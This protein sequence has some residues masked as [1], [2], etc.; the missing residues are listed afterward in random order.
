MADQN[1]EGLKEIMVFDLYL[2]E[3]LK[4]R[5]LFAAD[6][7]NLKERLR[8]FYSDERNIRRYLNGYEEY[9]SKQTRRMTHVECFS[10]DVEQTCVRGTPCFLE[11]YILFDYRN[12]NA[13]YGQ[14]RFISIPL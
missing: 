10:I 13:M 4:N 2:R 8:D 12:R 1:T 11:N 5:P 6:Q 3:N 14:A 9:D 7:S